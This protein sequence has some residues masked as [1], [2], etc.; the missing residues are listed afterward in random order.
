MSYRPIYATKG[1]SYSR[2]EGAFLRDETLCKREGFIE[3]QNYETGNK[4]TQ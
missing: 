2:K 3:P 4:K 1:R